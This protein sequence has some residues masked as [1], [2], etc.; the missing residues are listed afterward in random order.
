MTNDEM[1]A[2]A[3][4]TAQTTFD[5]QIAACLTSLVRATQMHITATMRDVGGDEWQ[6]AMAQSVGSLEKS[7]DKLAEALDLLASRADAAGKRWR[8]AKDAL[9]ARK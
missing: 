5:T 4:E 2:A 7:T 3:K 6:E 1:L 8:D 9:D